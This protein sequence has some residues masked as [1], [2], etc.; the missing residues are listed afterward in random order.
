MHSMIG[1]PSL[2]TGLERLF[3]PIL[4]FGFELVGEN[5]LYMVFIP[6]LERE[7]WFASCF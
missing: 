5:I 7:T 4:S 1:K 6:R 2:G 3:Q